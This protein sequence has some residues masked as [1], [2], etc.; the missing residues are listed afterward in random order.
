MLIKDKQERLF[1]PPLIRGLLQLIQFPNMERK[2][3]L[4]CKTKE[5]VYSVSVV[6]IG[7]KRGACPRHLVFENMSFWVS[8]QGYSGRC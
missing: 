5:S 2:A 4:P 1:H 3:L 6:S 8:F 7:G